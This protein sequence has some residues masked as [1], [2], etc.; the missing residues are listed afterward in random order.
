MV[1][2]FLQ[3]KCISAIIYRCDAVHVHVYELTKYVISQRDTLK[4]SANVPDFKAS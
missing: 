4:D 1:S 3:K 2:C